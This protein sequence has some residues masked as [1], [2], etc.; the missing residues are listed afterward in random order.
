MRDYLQHGRRHGENGSDPIPGIGSTA[1][2]KF[3]PLNGV[4]IANA[5]FGSL[6]WDNKVSGSDLLDLSDPL[7][8]TVVSDGVY[9]VTVTA[10]TDP[11]STG[12]YYTLYLT[13]DSTAEDAVAAH[14]SPPSIAAINNP[15]VSCSLT[16]F[17]PAGG[18]INASVYNGDGVNSVVFYIYTAIVQRIS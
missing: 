4:S 17:I 6:T 10:S 14:D 1:R 2:E 8:P 5:A 16:Y 9:A 12:G 15:F 11:I 7:N 13:L 3:V 18:I